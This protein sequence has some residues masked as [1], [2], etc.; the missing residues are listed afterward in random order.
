MSEWHSNKS[1]H[2]NV[3]SLTAAIETL[4]ESMEIEKKA[5]TSLQF[6]GSFKSLKVRIQKTVLNDLNY[7][8]TSDKT[9]A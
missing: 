8:K 6:K 5:C 2:S 1:R 9:D 7:V 3:R 4:F